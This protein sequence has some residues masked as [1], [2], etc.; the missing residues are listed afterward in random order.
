MEQNTSTTMIEKVLDDAEKILEAS[1]V[2][3]ES[4]SDI[5]K[6]LDIIIASIDRPKFF[7]RLS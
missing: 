3:E 4:I 1:K 2:S 7:K 6:S 5:E